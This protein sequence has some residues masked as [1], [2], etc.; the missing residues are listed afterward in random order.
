MAIFWSWYLILYFMAFAFPPWEQGERLSLFLLTELNFFEFQANFSLWIPNS[1]P[2]TWRSE[3]VGGGPI[4]GGTPIAGWFF[5]WK[6]PLKGMVYNGKSQSKM[7]DL[8]V[9]LF[10]EP[11]CGLGYR[12]RGLKW[13]VKIW[14][15]S[16]LH[17]IWLFQVTKRKWLF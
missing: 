1:V 4:H 15:I 6:I 8:G 3:V 5:S 13:W 14:G 2:R 7:D 17:Q 11:P 10:Q 16:S 9:P 12:T